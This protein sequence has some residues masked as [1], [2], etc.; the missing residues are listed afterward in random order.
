[1]DFSIAKRA[2]TSLTLVVPCY[3][4]ASCLGNTVEVLLATIK[5]L[6]DSG[7][8]TGD[9]RICLIDDGSTD[10]TW[11]IISALSRSEKEC[12]GIRLTRNFGHQNA[13]LAG[14][15]SAPGDVLVSLDADLQDDPA[16][17]GEM[18]DAYGNG[19]DIVCGVRNDRSSDGFLKRFSARAFYKLTRLLGVPG[20]ADHADFRLM[21]RSAIESLREYPEVNLFLRALVPQLG[22][23]Q[24]VVYYSR[25]QRVAGRSKYSLARMMSLGLTGITSFSAAPLRLIALTGFM[26]C[27]A[28]LVVAGWA[29]WVRLTSDAAVPGWASSVIPMYLLGGIQLLS[30]G[31]VGEYVAKL[32]L[33]AKARP[34]YLLREIL[35]LPQASYSGRD[36]DGHQANADQWFQH[37]HQRHIRQ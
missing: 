29:L 27:I 23:R 9:C 15:L 28:S 11:Q 13:L 8:V 2:P 30:I 31:V 14:L 19:A 34:R 25:K 37:G 22:Y 33:E 7:R 24:A 17:I 10:N 36:Q 21:S 35:G 16:V 12:C 4:E 3:N 18:L 1:M 20:T 5:A 32:Y 6:R 26:I